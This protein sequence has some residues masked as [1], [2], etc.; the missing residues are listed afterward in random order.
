MLVCV[1]GQTLSQCAQS[2]IPYLVSRLGVGCSV[3]LRSGVSRWGSVRNVSDGS[4]SEMLT[5]DSLT[6]RPLDLNI[7]AYFG[8]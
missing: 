4:R 3:L 6:A 5:V 7:L 1:P 2:R 8:L